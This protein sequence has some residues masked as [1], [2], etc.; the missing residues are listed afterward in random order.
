M[1]SGK[2]E[3]TGTSQGNLGVFE[4]RDFKYSVNTPVDAATGMATGKARGSVFEIDIDIMPKTVLVLQSLLTNETLKGKITFMKP[5]VAGN[6]AK[7][8]EIEIEKAHCFQFE[9]I[10]TSVDK[11]PMTVRLKLSSPKATFT[12]VDGGIQT[13]YDNSYS[14]AK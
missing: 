11:A 12:A 10:F 2:V 6:N 9:Q 7:Y 1:F 4:L 5:N 8:M 14:Y 3:L 13:S